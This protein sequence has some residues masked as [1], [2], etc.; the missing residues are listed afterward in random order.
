MDIDPSAE[1][2]Y[3]EQEVKEILER[4]LDRQQEQ[5]LGLTRAEL[6]EIATELGIDPHTVREATESLQGE[7]QEREQREQ[8]VERRRTRREREV[9][10]FLRSLL[11][12]LAVN[13]GLFALDYLT[14]PGWWAQWVLLVWGVMLLLRGSRLLL[15]RSEEQE[16]SLDRREQ[17][18]ERRHK[19]AN[20]QRERRKHRRLEKKRARGQKREKKARRERERRSRRH[21]RREASEQFEKAVEQGVNSLLRAAAK[22]IEEA[23]T[24]SPK[25][26]SKDTGFGR[27]VAAQKRKERGDPEPAQE[28]KPPAKVPKVRVATPESE[29]DDEANRGE[30]HPEA[31]SHRHDRRGRRR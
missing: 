11:S 3:D 26:T 30:A 23:S 7:Q 10:D 1:R 21:D 15:P 16:E 13:A 18:R 22:K 8:I 19:A 27:F 20:E 24:K 4:A 14:G 29:R 6:E 31:A 28:S 9:R 17:E 12:A 25:E 5:K 2:E